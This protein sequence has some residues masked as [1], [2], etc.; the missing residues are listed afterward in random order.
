MGIRE[1]KKKGAAGFVGLT[2]LALALWF[3]PGACVS[4]PPPGPNVT[5]VVLMWLK[6]PERTQDRAELIR[7]ARSLRM[8]PG[9]LR[10]ETGRAVPP[11]GPH[12]PQDFDLG[13]VVTFRDRAAL[14]R[15]E[16]DPRHS[17]AMQRYLHPLVRRYEVYNL[18]IR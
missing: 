9:V 10:V 12:T 17:I 7:A 15:Y 4:P 14:N 2:A 3:L 13:V 6:H 8:I 18:G 16:K 1:W 11:I 5:H